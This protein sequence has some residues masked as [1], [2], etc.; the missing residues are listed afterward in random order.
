MSGSNEAAG[1][2]ASRR[3]RLRIGYSL[4]A[5]LGATGIA[6]GPARAAPSPPN[7]S[8]D[9]TFGKVAGWSIGYSASMDGCL[10]AATY[11]DRKSVV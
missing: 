10:A 11:E 1:S 4:L 7:L 5:I 8:V 2:R 6:G 9:K 3:W